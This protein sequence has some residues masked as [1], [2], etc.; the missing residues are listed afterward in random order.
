M[1]KFV[2]KMTNTITIKQ[3]QR[4]LTSMSAAGSLV[5]YYDE[6]GHLLIIFRDVTAGAML[7]FLLLY[8]WKNTERGG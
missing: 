4:K 8:C 6:V 5:Q 3:N 2:S 7:F 1:R